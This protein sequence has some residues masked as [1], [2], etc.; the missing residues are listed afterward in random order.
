MSATKR[1]VVFPDDLWQKIEKAAAKEGHR[2]GKPQSVAEWIRT[3]CEM[4]LRERSK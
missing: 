4:R 1:N 3:A 2:A